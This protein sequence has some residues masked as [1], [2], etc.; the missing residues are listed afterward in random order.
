MQSLNNQLDLDNSITSFNRCDILGSFGSQERYELYKSTFSFFKLEKTFSY[1]KSLFISKLHYWL[2]KCGRN[3]EDSEAKWIYNTIKDWAEQFNWSVSTLKRI[4]Y[5]L[6][7]E[8]II[9]HRQV[10][11][12]IE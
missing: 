8:G 2:N 6:E 5:S 10:K 7:E 12:R 3:I 11:K 4:V 9:R 1:K